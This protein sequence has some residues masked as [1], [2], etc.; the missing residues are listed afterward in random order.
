M[1]LDVLITCTRNKMLLTTGFR[2]ETNTDLYMQIQ[3]CN[4]Q[5]ETHMH[6]YNGNRI[7]QKFKNQFQFVPMKN[8]LKMNRII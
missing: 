5:S 4:M 7:I 8:Y 1:F 2:K 6:P 3:I